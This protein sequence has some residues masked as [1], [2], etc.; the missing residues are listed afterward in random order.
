MFLRNGLLCPSLLLGLMPMYT[1]FPNKV[2]ETGEICK[3]ITLLMDL[4]QSDL[5][6]AGDKRSR[7]ARSGWLK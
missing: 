2:T 3:L 7:G 6:C 1:M 5:K 4:T